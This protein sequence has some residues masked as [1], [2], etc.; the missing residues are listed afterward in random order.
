M[1]LYTTLS[2]LICTGKVTIATKRTNN[3][4][5]NYHSNQETDNAALNNHSNQETDNAALNCHSNQENKQCCT[6]L[7]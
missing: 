3:A 5:L 6:E 7:P 1:D 4:A 2:L